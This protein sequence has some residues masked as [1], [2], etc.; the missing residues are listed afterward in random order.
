MCAKAKCWTVLPQWHWLGA[1]RVVVDTVSKRKY[2]QVIGQ[3]GGW[4]W[5]QR[6]LRALDG[7]AQKHAVSISN[8]AARW[9]LDR[10]AVAAIII[11][12]NLDLNSA[13]C[14]LFM[15]HQITLQHQ[16]RKPCN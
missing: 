5:F 3:V 9:V 2:G 14:P 16:V 4:E 8:V 11:G 13:L 7:V 1:C 15:P 10:P 12:M 6:L